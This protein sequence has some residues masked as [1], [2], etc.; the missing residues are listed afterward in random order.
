MATS[1][2][3]SITVGVY[4]VKTKVSC[5]LAVHPKTSKATVTVHLLELKCHILSPYSR[6][7]DIFTLLLWLCE[8]SPPCG[9]RASLWLLTVLPA[10]LHAAELTPTSS[11]RLHPCSHAPSVYMSQCQCVCVCGG[12]V[13]K[14]MF[15]EIFFE[16]TDI[17]SWPLTEKKN[18]THMQHWCPLRC[19]HASHSCLL[20]FC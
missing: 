15:G 17:T 6:M 7:S 3:F 9:A 5:I 20:P 2:N 10:G 8:Y 18:H 14:L 12:W 16:R 13:P 1:M 11:T 19:S 4:E